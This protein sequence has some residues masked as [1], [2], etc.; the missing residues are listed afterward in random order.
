MDQK[1]ILRA[2]NDCETSIRVSFPNEKPVR[3]DVN[4]RVLSKPTK[5]RHALW[6]IGEAREFARE[7][8]L[9]KAFRWLG[10]IQGVLWSLGIITINEAK[11]A[12]R[13]KL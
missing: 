2:L 10:F 11:D 13:P 4:G 5:I 1:D 12:N 6:M 7:D 9:P 8:R 3:A